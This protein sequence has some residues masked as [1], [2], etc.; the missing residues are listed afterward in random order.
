[1]TCTVAHNCERREQG[2]FVMQIDVLL[3]HDFFKQNCKKV[4]K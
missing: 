3:E 1:M 4:L 2:P